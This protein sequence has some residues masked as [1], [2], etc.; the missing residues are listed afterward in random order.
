MIL[1]FWVDR[2]LTKDV[3]VYQSAFR[4]SREDKNEN[5]DRIKGCC[6]QGL[7]LDHFRSEI[8]YSISWESR[9]ATSIPHGR[10]ESIP[11]EGRCHWIH[12]IAL[13]L[14]S[15]YRRKEIKIKIRSIKYIL[16]DFSADETE[17]QLFYSHFF[18]LSL[19]LVL[20]LAFQ[21]FICY[22]KG[23]FS[24]LQAFPWLNWLLFLQ[25]H[26]KIWCF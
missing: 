12:Y 24:D 25:R 4:T 20:F 26:R 3:L 15:L 10:I 19:F 11:K 1:A 13:F 7:L 21:R 2:M 22:S 9:H 16:T 23:C 5:K 17:C 18:W 6:C 14:N 8:T